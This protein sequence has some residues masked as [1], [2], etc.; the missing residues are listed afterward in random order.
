MSTLN[1]AAL[2]GASFGEAVSRFWSRFATFSGRASRAEYWWAILFNVLVGVVLSVI[3]SIIGLGR[4][5]GD[6]ELLGGLYSLITI[7]PCVAMSVRRLHDIGRT[8][9]WVFIILLPV[10]GFIVLL[11]FHCIRGTEGPNRF[12]ETEV[13]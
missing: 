10:I 5:M 1:N 3:D 7:L 9:W 11:V 12:G 8:G 13:A 4:S 2:Q 6:Y